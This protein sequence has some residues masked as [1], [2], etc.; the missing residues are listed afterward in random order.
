MLRKILAISVF[1]ACT[2]LGISAESGVFLTA[3]YNAPFDNELM[4]NNVSFGANF[5]FWGIFVASVDMYTKVIYGEDA[6]MHV[7]SI[8]PTGMFSWGL[9]LQ[10]PLGNFFF[11]FDWNRYYSNSDDS[12]FQEFCSSYSLGFHVKFTDTLGLEVYRRT[13][14]DFTDI[15]SIDRSEELDMIGVGA[16]IFL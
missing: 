13:M 8:D 7:D 1:C 12:G 10:I 6:F 5:G 4:D 14:I 11:D 3:D 9:G 16:M 2:V 15:S